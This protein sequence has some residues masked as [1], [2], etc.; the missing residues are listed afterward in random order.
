M[1]G[2]DIEGRGKEEEGAGR[3]IHRMMEWIMEGIDIERRGKEEE[4]TGR[5]RRGEEEIY[6]EWW[7]ESRKGLI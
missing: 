4:G 6:I 2:I 7:S 5:E 3:D 1:E